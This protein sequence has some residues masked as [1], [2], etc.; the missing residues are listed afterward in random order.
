MVFCPKCGSKNSD[1]ALR[2]INCNTRLRNARYYRERS[3][4]EICFGDEK[5]SHIWGLVLGLL[6]ISWGFTTI[7]RD[8][9][10]W[11]TWNQIWPFALIIIGFYIVYANMK[12]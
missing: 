9:I 6:L 12:Q 8:V 7:F 3:S 2:C 1:D 10:G 11:L 5:N 4:D